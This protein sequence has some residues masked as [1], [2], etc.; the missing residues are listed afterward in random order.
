MHS[1]TQQRCP[2]IFR[3]HYILAVWILWNLPKWCCRT[4]H[5]GLVGLSPLSVV[6]LEWVPDK[7]WGSKQAYRM[8]HQPISMVLQCSLNAW[9]KELATGDQRR[10]TWSGSALESC[11]RRCAT[12]IHSLVYFPLLRTMDWMCTLYFWHERCTPEMKWKISCS[13]RFCDISL[14][15]W[16]LPDLFPVSDLS[17]FPLTFR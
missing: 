9:L 12:Q 11:L 7:S 15:F 2:V 1:I 5:P 13:W 16:K 17:R 14:L 10:L 8:I 3:V 6:R 4:R